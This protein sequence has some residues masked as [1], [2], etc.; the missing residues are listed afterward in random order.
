MGR[1]DGEDYDDLHYAKADRDEAVRNREA[2][3]GLALRL[4]PSL[5]YLHAL[6]DLGSGTYGGFSSVEAREKL[7]DLDVDA[8]RAN[9]YMARWRKLC[10]LDFYTNPFRKDLPEGAWH[11][12]D[13]ARRIV[14]AA[15]PAA[16]KLRELTS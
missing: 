1:Y 9:R 10:L 3:A 7:A 6:K 2:L 15:G 14:D 4:E 16:K 13:T 5:C 12:S 8:E 11:L